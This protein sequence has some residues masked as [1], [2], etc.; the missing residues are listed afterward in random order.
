MGIFMSG[1]HSAGFEH[2]CAG[3]F[4][5]PWA[6]FSTCEMGTASI[7]HPVMEKTGS[8]AVSEGLAWLGASTCCRALS[9]RTMKAEL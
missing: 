9:H 6:P 4:G 5:L 8:T 3:W 1:Q 7:F 2:P